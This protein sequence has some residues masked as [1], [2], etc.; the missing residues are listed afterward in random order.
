MSSMRIR[1]SVLAAARPNVDVIE[2]EAV[3]PPGAT[4]AVDVRVAQ[5]LS[6][7]GWR[8]LS[9]APRPGRIRATANR[10]RVILFMT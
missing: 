9:A 5:K 7:P 4:K 10:L 8:T 1:L 2:A 3:L 6:T